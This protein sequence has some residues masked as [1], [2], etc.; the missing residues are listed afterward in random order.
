[1]HT[2]LP[3]LVSDLMLELVSI[4]LLQEAYPSRLL[5]QAFS[6]TCLS[7]D[8]CEASITAGQKRLNHNAGS[9]KSR[10]QSS[11]LVGDFSEV[12]ALGGF[13]CGQSIDWCSISLILPCPFPLYAS[14][15]K[16]ETGEILISFCILQF[17]V[18]ISECRDCF[19]SAEGNQQPFSIWRIFPRD[20]S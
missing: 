7:V 16:A 2:N 14:A 9:I 8:L 13:L 20:D 19:G 5:L 6:H 18:L 10:I 15:R 1:M 11:L 17:A 3:M 4:S 12:G